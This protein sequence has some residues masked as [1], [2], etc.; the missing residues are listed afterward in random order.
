MKQCTGPCGEVKDLSMFNKSGKGAGGLR[1]TC[2]ICDSDY[3]KAHY[4]ANKEEKAAYGKA[5]K[6]AFPEK[7]KATNKSWRDR[8]PMEMKALRLFYRYG[9]NSRTSQSKATRPRGFMC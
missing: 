6:T 1:A 8:H 2:K 7:V 5:Y 9:P 3:N 4:Q